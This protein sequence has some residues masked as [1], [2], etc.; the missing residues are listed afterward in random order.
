MDIIQEDRNLVTIRLPNENKSSTIK[1]KVDN[2]NKNEGKMNS[3]K[4]DNGVLIKMNFK[5]NN[6]YDK[7]IFQDDLNN[8]MVKIPI[9]NKAKESLTKH[10]GKLTPEVFVKCPKELQVKV[11]NLKSEDVILQSLY[12]K[13]FYDKGITFDSFDSDFEKTRDMDYI[14]ICLPVLKKPY[15][16]KKFH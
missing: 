7:D 9:K 1:L 5:Y 3:I 4:K 13:L 6:R 16:Y 14:R 11:H 2:N 12:P 15:P 8:I 10:S